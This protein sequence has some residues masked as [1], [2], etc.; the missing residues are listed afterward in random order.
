MGPAPVT[1]RSDVL[2]CCRCGSGE[3]MEPTPTLELAEIAAS[4][5]PVPERAQGMLEQLR[6]LVPFDAAWLASADPMSSS[7]TSL[8][9]ADLDEATLRY[10]AGPQMARDIEAT[11]AD[12]RRP[13]LSPSDLPYPATELPTW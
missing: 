10:L 1:S 5:G 12:R 11:H 6:R 8:A 7:Y 13:P 9:S 2:P 4:S 3:P